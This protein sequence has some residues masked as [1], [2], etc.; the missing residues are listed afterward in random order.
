[1]DQL[2]VKFANHKFSKNWGMFSN[3]GKGLLWENIEIQQGISVSHPQSV[4]PIHS[5]QGFRIFNLGDFV[6]PRVTQVVSAACASLTTL[7]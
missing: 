4:V 3:R 6:D 7:P 1:M 2:K 5:F